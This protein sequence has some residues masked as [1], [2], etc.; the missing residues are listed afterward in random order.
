MREC[1]SQWNVGANGD[2]LEGGVETFDGGGLISN[3][4]PSRIELT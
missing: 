3:A 1:A 2:V 4:L